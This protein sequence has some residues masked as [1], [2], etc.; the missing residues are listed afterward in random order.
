MEEEEEE[1]EEESLD[2]NTSFEIGLAVI[3][4]LQFHLYDRFSHFYKQ[5]MHGELLK[6]TS[7]YI[8]AVKCP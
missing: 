4:Q 6:N 1:E 3:Q 5:E 8:S 7:S 2:R